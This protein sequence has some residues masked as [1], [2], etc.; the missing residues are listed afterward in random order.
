MFVPIK[1][2]P[3]NWFITESSKLNFW[4]VWSSSWWIKSRITRIWM[5]NSWITTKTL[6]FRREPRPNSSRL[7]IFNFMTFRNNSIWRCLI[8]K[9]DFSLSFCSNYLK[10]AKSRSSTLIWMIRSSRRASRKYLMEKL[11]R[12]TSSCRST[13]SLMA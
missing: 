5:I 13:T 4:K 3:S 2:P 1:A 10:V 8:S 6:S 9:M 7:S 11:L 12:F